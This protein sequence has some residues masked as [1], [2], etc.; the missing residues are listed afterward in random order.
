M[1][2]LLPIYKSG[3]DCDID[4]DCEETHICEFST[5]YFEDEFLHDKLVLQPHNNKIQEYFDIIFPKRL[6]RNKIFYYLPR[7]CKYIFIQYDL[8][9][10]YR[11]INYYYINNILVFVKEIICMDG[12]RT[13]RQS[14]DNF[15]EYIKL[16]DE[17]KYNKISI[18]TR[19]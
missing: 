18:D 16:L 19:Q 1:N 11:N 17:K 4:S 6:Y 7:D 5:E 13:H 15:E 10:G 14:M 12:I 9:C 2:D 3:C 8:D